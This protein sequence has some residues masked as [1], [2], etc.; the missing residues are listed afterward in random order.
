[1]IFTQALSIVALAAAVVPSALAA[2]SAR[3]AAK[4]QNDDPQTSFTLD[5]AV[6]MAHGLDDGQ[7]VPD[8]GQVPSLTSGN[9]FINFC[10]TVNAPIT[11]GQ[12]LV[13]GSCNP[14][15]MGSIP[16]TANMPSAKFIFP[17]N[18]DASLSENQTF[19][20][21]LAIS[22][23]ETGNFVNAKQKYYAAPQQLNDAGQ[24]IG[25]SHVVVE[26]LTA[27]DQTKPTD[28]RKF[29]FF[30][31]F[32]DVAQNGVL[33]A[34]VTTGLLAGAYRM[35]SI[36]TAA[37]HQP[38]LAPVA[39]HGSMDDCS[40]FTINPK[41]GNNANNGGNTGTGGAGGAATPPPPATP[42]PAKAKTVTVKRGDT[43][44]KIAKKAG[45]SLA[46]LLAKNKNVNKR[47]TNLEIGE[48]LVVG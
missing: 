43:C 2:P 26:L 14:T 5:P 25:H 18:G 16:S 29:A 44:S 1:M 41:G 39:Q 37:N 11:D 22:N 7:D 46:T 33:T 10:L 38:T 36:N 6:I 15:P 13:N 32:N 42:P 40:Y 8:P 34:N 31:G 17:P 23:L 30:K 35:C 45:I 20:I 12:Q 4:R 47:C 27:L 9:N 24:I 28:P 21:Q 3:L 48:K 19:T